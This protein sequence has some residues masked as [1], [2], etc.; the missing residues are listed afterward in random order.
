LQV[1]VSP[2][3]IMN[4]YEF[5]IVGLGVMGANL[6]F[7]ALKHGYSVVG[8][9]RDTSSVERF[10][11][12]GKEVAGRADAVMG[13]T[14]AQEFARLLR[15][16]RSILAMVPAGAPVDGVIEGLEPHLERED[17]LIDGGNSHFKDTRRR[18][19]TLAKG[20]IHFI[21]MGVSGGESGARHG[22]S[23]M[24]GGSKAG[25]ERLRPMLEALSAKVGGEPCVAWL[26][27]GAAGHY[28]KMVHNGIEYGLMELIAETYDLMHRGFGLDNAALRNIYTRWSRSAV[29]GYLLDITAH[30]FGRRDQSSDAFLVDRIEDIAE[31]KG[32]GAWTSEDALHLGVPVPNIDLAVAMRGLSADKD[33]RLAASRHWPGP[34]MESKRV[35]EPF[36]DTLQAALHAAMVMTYSQGMHLLREADRE[37]H[38]GLHLAEVARIWRGGCIIRA[39][40]LED[41]RQAY[42]RNARL[43]HPLDDPDLAAQVGQGQQP[44]REV[45]CAAAE[46]GIPAPG[47]MAAL[48]YYDAYRSARLPANLIQAQRDYFGAHKFRRVDSEGLFHAQW[49]EEAR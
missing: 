29:Q 16:P 49:E 37:Y 6:G 33:R 12:A 10:V 40:L 47:F 26:G 7:N 20:C 14:S 8:L 43:S 38:Y 3:R 25:W 1:D 42:R 32:T 13:V 24:P 15:R 4:E 22:P 21:G 28:V 36:V 41:L 39:G 35:A 34:G 48:G 18:A 46:W 31:Q 19:M 5:G 45:A 17:V 9:D 11:R 27:A 30:I 44:L 23:L 2:E